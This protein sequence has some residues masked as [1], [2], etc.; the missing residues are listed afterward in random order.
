V[1]ITLEGPDGAGKTTQAARL[2][3]GLRARGHD[4]LA[5][6]EPGG[7]EL[8]AH[9]RALLV[10]RGGVPIDAR[11]EALLFSACRAQL[12]ADVIRPT[13]ARGGIVVGDRFADSTLAYQGAGRGL[14]MDELEALVRIATGG[15]QPDMTFLLDVPASVGLERLRPSD[16]AAPGQNQI[17]FFEELEMPADWNR[18]EDEGRA[19]QERVR[20]AY[21][22]LAERE[23]SRWWVVDA[24]RPLDVVAEELLAVVLRVLGADARTSSMHLMAQIES[25]PHE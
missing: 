4:V 16:A 6:H 24:T 23:P 17:S 8:G 1:F 3:D 11:A 5:I 20:G 21:K 13:L 15:L 12:V 9:I 22:D 19:F 7:T 2:V 25:K 18:F 10:Q 14:P